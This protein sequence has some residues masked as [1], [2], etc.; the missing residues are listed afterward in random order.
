MDFFAKLRNADKMLLDG[1]TGQAVVAAG[2]ALEELLQHLYQ[3]ALPKLKA[4][5]QQ[6]I[7]QK[8]EQIGKGKA[9]SE[10]TLG[11]LVGL[12]REGDLF[13]LCET[14]LG[15]KLPRLRAVD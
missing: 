11:Q 12:F 13:G 10:L 5:D 4:K 2:Q 8:L 3:T 14:A 6:T 9:A 15:L 7:S 1:Y